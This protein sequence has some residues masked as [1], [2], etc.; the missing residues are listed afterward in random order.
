MA[1]A[2]DVEF[3]EDARAQAPLTCSAGLAQRWFMVGCLADVRDPENAKIPARPGD[4]L[5]RNAS[6]DYRTR[7]VR[8]PALGPTPDGTGTL[9]PL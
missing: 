7:V 4:A 5:T 6:G 8:P 9:D 1:D 3:A 2:L